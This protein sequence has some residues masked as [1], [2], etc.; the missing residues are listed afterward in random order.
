M[1]IDAV[2]GLCLG[3]REALMLHLRRLTLGER[4]VA[5]FTCPNPDCKEVLSHDMNVK[6]LLL[7][8]YSRWQKAYE[9]SFATE[10][11]RCLVRFRL[12]DGRDQERAA[13]TALSRGLEAAADELVRGCILEAR[14]E[15]GSPLQSISCAVA[16]RL[17]SCMSELDPQAELLLEL[18]CPSCGMSFESLFDAA[19]FFMRELSGVRDLFYS[20]VHMLAYHYHWPLHEI[21]GLESMNR[22]RYVQIL[23]ENLIKG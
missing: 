9:S 11:G 13:I 21:L 14:D 8:V 23:E 17:S 12:P 1:G 10:E 16:A 18:K 3:D 2:R 4:I 6:S 7:P 15:D 20:D 19:G 22:R 5:L